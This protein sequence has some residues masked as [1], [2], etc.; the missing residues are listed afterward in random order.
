M[1][2]PLVTKQDRDSLAALAAPLSVPAEPAWIAARVASLL[3]PYYEKNTPQGI[4]EMEA[5]DWVLALRLYPRWAID[6]AVRWWKGLDND[7]RHRR[8]LEGDISKRATAEMMAVNAAKIKI[9][10]FDNG[11]RPLPKPQYRPPAQ[12]TDEER[13]RRAEVAATM[14]RGFG[15]A[16]ID[17]GDA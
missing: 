1:Q 10:G 4:R 15:R 7:N 8:P 9:S 12:I 2:P 16:G 11:I 13:A 17:G 3:S 5:D 6:A 14:L